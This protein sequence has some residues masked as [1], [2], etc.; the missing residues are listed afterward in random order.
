[1]M[2]Q[3]SFS[4]LSIKRKVFTY[5]FLSTVLFLCGA[6]IFTRTVLTNQ[7][8]TLAQNQ[9]EQKIE[10]VHKLLESEIERL[11]QINAD[12]AAWDETYHFIQNRNEEYKRNNLIPASFATLGLKILIYF[13]LNKNIIYAGEYNPEKELIIYPDTGICQQI[14]NVLFNEGL[15]KHLIEGEMTILSNEPLIVSAE[16]ILTSQHKGPVKGYLVM[17]R[18]LNLKPIMELT[19][20]TINIDYDDDPFICKLETTQE[21]ILKTDIKND[22]ITASHKFYDVL[23]QRMLSVN[24]SEENKIVRQGNRASFYILCAI[25]IFGFFIFLLLTIGL[26]NIIIKP[27]LGISRQLKEIDLNNIEKDIVLPEARDE[28]FNLA[29]D[30]NNMLNVIEKQKKEVFESEERYRDLV[31]NA[32]VGILVDDINGNVIYYNDKLA[33]IFGYTMDEF[34]K[35]KLQDYIHPD[36]L[37]IIREYHRSRVRGEDAPSRYEIKGISKDGKIIN[38][39][40][41]TIILKKDDKMVGTRNYIIDITYRK[42]LEE[43]LTTQS[44][45]DELTGMLNRRGF[46]TFAEQ[47]IEVAKKTKKGFYLFYCDINNMKILNDKY[48]HSTGDIMLKETAHI[49]KSSFR[50]S[51]IIARVGGDEFI[52]IANEA[53]PESIDVMLNRLK[54]NIEKINESNNHPAL[55]LSIGYA[56]FDPNDS[57]MLD[58]IINIADKMMYEEKQKFKDK[59]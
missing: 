43:K 1:M 45:T 55:S 54:T 59:R 2:N 52:V 29:T 6:I 4:N 18:R 23:N 47:Q 11:V 21:H 22:S 38:L 36:Y 34:K 37:K 39:E 46:K 53:Q 35:L 58:D 28:I 12:W 44:I 7:F 20:L 16:S 31:E 9:I 57:K 32:E 17:A 8:K 14:S 33:K 49:L 42:K 15:R 56:Y 5:I 3:L 51:D 50:K 13:D 27:L 40:V 41:N 19:G 25:I 48:G 26:N 10:M 30:I 24:V